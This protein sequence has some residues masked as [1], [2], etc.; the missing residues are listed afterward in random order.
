MPDLIEYGC[1]AHQL[2]LLAKDLEIPIVTEHILKVIKYFRNKH[3]PAG[4]YKETEGTKLLMPQEVRWNTM[5]DA[6]SSHMSNRGRLIQ[7]CQDHRAEID[8]DIQKIVN[9]QQIVTNAKDLISRLHPIAVAVDRMQRDN[10]TIS[11]AVE[12]WNHLQKDLEGQPLFVQKHFIKRRDIA[13]GPAHYLANILDH[14]FLGKRLSNNQKEEAFEYLSKIN[15]E[16]V[17]FAM[18]VMAEEKPFPKYLFGAHFKSTHPLLWWKSVTVHES[19]WP[20]KCTFVKL[21]DQLFTA[22]ATC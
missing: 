14:R 18:K 11:V 10:T 16:F 12:I 5:N 3:L 4:L 20:D 7:L 13:L 8:L 9:D 6:I 21:C 2:N 22:V 19:D 1:S 15:P 17:P